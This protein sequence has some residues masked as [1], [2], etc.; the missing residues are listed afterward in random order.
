MKPGPV[1]KIDKR[2][3]VLSKTF[4]A[5]FMSENMTSLLFFRFMANLEQSGSGIPNV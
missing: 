4:D 5:D 3:K 2:K 1:T